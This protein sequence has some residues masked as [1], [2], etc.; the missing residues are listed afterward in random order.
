MSPG[1]GTRERCS[2]L[3]GAGRLAVFLASVASRS[4]V[5]RQN[6]CRTR[7]GR[8]VVMKC[9][10]NRRSKEAGQVR[11]GSRLY[12]KYLQSAGQRGDRRRLGSAG[13]QEPGEDRSAV[14]L[15]GSL[16]A[17]RHRRCR[18]GRHPLLQLRHVHRRGRA[19]ERL[20]PGAGHPHRLTHQRPGR[21]LLPG[22]SGRHRRRYCGV[23]PAEGGGPH[24]R[25]ERRLHASRC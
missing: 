13:R 5:A 12:D 6:T 25:H 18:P 24:S 10:P 7:A 9:S 22:R 2:T 14:R 20:K 23:D 19:G 16:R 21:R 1:L 17:R 8:Q 4:C 11:A 3:H 15:A